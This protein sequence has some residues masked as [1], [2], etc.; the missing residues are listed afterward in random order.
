[1]ALAV[2]E[3][4]TF[5]FFIY[6]LSKAVPNTARLLLTHLGPIVSTGLPSQS[7]VH[8][9]QLRAQVLQG[10]QGRERPHR[11]TL[12]DGR[13]RRRQVLHQRRRHCRRNESE[14]VG[15][16]SGRIQGNSI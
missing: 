6:F 4:V 14:S 11:R 2:G 8:Q 15:K 3:P 5:W 7:G 16:I 9:L 13:L 1:M 10:R 12:A